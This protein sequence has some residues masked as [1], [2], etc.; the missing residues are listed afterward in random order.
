MNLLYRTGAEARQDKSGY[1]Q[2]S[3]NHY[4]GL[5]VRDCLN[6][7]EVTAFFADGLFQSEEPKN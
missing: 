4:Y 7:K 5:K 2:A 3:D 1:K 6:Y